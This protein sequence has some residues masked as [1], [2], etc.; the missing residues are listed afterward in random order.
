MCFE[1]D[2]WAGFFTPSQLRDQTVW[3]ERQYESTI[4]DYG[5]GK[6]GWIP[7]TEKSRGQTFSS[8][9][10][11]TAPR[12]ALH[13]RELKLAVSDSYALNEFVAVLLASPEGA[14]R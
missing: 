3:A 11:R 2:S 8:G 1:N 10:L 12:A 14:G 4:Y 9:L 6:L 5:H 13:G 7:R